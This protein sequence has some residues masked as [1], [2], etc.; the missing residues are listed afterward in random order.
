VLRCR[1]VPLTDYPIEKA[2]LKRPEEVKLPEDESVEEQEEIVYRKD[3]DPIEHRK[4][5]RMVVMKKP[6]RNDRFDEHDRKSCTSEYDKDNHYLPRGF[7]MPA[8]L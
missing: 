1:L 4:P 3:Q 6:I 2:F 8:V 5:C 7:H